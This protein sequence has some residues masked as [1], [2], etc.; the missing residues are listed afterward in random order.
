[1][2][3]TTAREGREGWKQTQYMRPNSEGVYKTVYHLTRK[4]RRQIVHDGRKVT[5]KAGRPAVDALN[6][7]DHRDLLHAQLKKVAKTMHR[8]VDAHEAK[9]GRF[10][11]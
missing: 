10:P 9:S 3:D 1:M 8:M 5:G 11:S 2:S 7:M 6:K 4:T